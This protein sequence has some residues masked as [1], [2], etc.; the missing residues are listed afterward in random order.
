MPGAAAKST[1]AD[2]AIP[3][4]DPDTQIDQQKPADD[5]AN[6]NNNTAGDVDGAAG[7][8]SSQQTDQAAPPQTGLN[9]LKSRPRIHVTAGQ[10]TKAKQQQPLPTIVN[11]KINPLVARRK[12]GG[13]AAATPPVAGTDVTQLCITTILYISCLFLYAD[14]LAEEIDGQDASDQVKDTVTEPTR[15]EATE[16]TETSSAETPR[17]LGNVCS[18][19]FP[20]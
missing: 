2:N 15:S 7:G 19:N 18:T 20:K 6:N 16:V 12:L 1:E 14:I 5:D 13:G 10:S 3:A 9:R 11:R 8:D 17:G 4:A